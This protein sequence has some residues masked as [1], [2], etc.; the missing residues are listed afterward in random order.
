MN[1]PM[2]AGS[3]LGLLEFSERGMWSGYR[4]YTAY[5]GNKVVGLITI[6]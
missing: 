5:C 2:A 3:I 6:G 1:H 4:I